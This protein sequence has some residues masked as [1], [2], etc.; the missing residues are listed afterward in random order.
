MRQDFTTP[1]YTLDVMAGRDARESNKRLATMLEKK[2]RREYSERV[3]FV[4]TQ[5]SLLFVRENTLLLRG[6]RGKRG[7]MGG[8]LVWECR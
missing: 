7:M 3:G 1:I 5:I 6:Q 8:R 4:R 2:W